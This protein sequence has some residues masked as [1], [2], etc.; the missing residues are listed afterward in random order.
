MKKKKTPPVGY[1]TDN[2]GESLALSGYTD[3]VFA[4]E[5][6]IRWGK[7]RMRYVYSSVP[8]TFQQRE[9]SSNM[10]EQCGPGKHKLWGTAED[11]R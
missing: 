6:K 9:A 3:I 7:G 2:A 5:S 8:Q 11:L 1:T 4:D 10:A